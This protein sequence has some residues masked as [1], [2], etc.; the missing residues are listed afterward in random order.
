M[1]LDRQRNRPEAD[2][3]CMTVLVEEVHVVHEV[4]LLPMLNIAV[5]AAVVV[6]MLPMLNNAVAVAVVP[7]HSNWRNQHSRLEQRLK[8]DIAT[9]LEQREWL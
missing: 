5:D 8:R 4:E 1:R 9:R 7:L 2:F 3:H 6:A